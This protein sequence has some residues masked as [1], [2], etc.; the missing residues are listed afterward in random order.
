MAKSNSVVDGKSE[1]ILRGGRL[2]A[3][4]RSSRS[5]TTTSVAKGMLS[6]GSLEALGSLEAVLCDNLFKLAGG[7]EIVAASGWQ[8]IAM[9][10]IQLNTLLVRIFARFCSANLLLLCRMAVTDKSKPRE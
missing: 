1:M 4:E 3:M 2:N 5:I 9:P 10:M 8:P 6:H 7:S